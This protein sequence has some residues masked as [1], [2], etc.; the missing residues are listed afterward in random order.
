MGLIDADAAAGTEIR[1]TVVAPTSAATTGAGPL[2]LVVFA[3]GFDLSAGRYRPMLER[4]ASAGYVVAAP[5][6]PGASSELTVPLDAEAIVD[7]PA[8]LRAVIDDLL[9]AEARDSLGV[10]VDGDRVGVMGHSDGGLTATALAFNASYRDPRIR[11]AVVL[12][13]GTIKFPG[14]LFPADSPPVLAVHGTED[15]VN[16]FTASIAVVNGVP[17]GTDAFLVSVEGGDH[18]AVFTTDPVAVDIGAIAVDFL[19][20]ELLGR[21]EARDA[22]LADATVPGRFT[23]RAR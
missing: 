9:T 17:D 12:T 6:L 22:L 23:V 1:I 2:P 21:D 4:V 18:L 13:G 20:L 10:A 15:G 14:D 16:P 7:Q 8:V 5:E 11:A 3:H 19:D